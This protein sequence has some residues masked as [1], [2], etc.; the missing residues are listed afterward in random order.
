MALAVLAL[1]GGQSDGWHHFLAPLLPRN[2]RSDF[3]SPA[4]LWDLIFRGKDISPLGT[5]PIQMKL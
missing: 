3:S 5:V 2:E 1:D 4:V